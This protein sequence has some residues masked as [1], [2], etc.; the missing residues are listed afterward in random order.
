[1]NIAVYPGTFDP[2]TNGH[3]DVINRAAALYDN[4]VLG[5]SE[6]SSKTLAF[7]INERLS[8]V[9][10][11]VSDNPKIIVESFDSLVVKFARKHKACAIIRGLRAVSDFEHE[12]QMAQLNK[13][14]AAEIE[15]LF[16][17]ASPEHAY[18]SSSAVKE[19]AEFG[20]DVSGLVPQ[21]VELKLKSRYSNK[22]QESEV[23]SRE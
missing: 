21:S 10:E 20:G 14:L 17:M 23:G 18:L 2:I 1:M 15:T 12:F 3:L 6:K 7:D 9:K 22:S 4:V 5:I 8:M 11:A 13:K 19:I 16:I